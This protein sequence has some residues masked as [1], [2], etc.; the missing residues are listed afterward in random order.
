MSRRTCN[1]QRD[2][3]STESHRKE[4]DYRTLHRLKDNLQALLE[5]ITQAC[6]SNTSDDQLANS[7]LPK[8]TSHETFLGL[9][10]KAEKRIAARHRRNSHPDLSKLSEDH[11]SIDEHFDITDKFQEYF[12]ELVSLQ[13]RMNDSIAKGIEEAL[14]Q[15]KD[16]H[17][18]MEA[19]Q[20]EKHMMGS[21]FNNQF[22]QLQKVEA[23]R[24]EEVERRLEAVKYRKEADTRFEKQRVQLSIATQ[25]VNRLKQVSEAATY[26]EGK[27]KIELKDQKAETREL[28]Y[29]VEA[30]ENRINIMRDTMKELAKYAHFG[31][32][33]HP[34]GDP[35]TWAPGMVNDF[36]DEWESMLE[37]NERRREVLKLLSKLV[38]LDIK[39]VLGSSVDEVRLFLDET[40]LRW[41][42]LEDAY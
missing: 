16:V 6:L 8:S 2:A 9:Y 27:L 26:R 10:V 24:N 20:R 13:K 12:M 17:C 31:H 3:T 36:F 4:L 23:E 34:V 18:N 41:R 42:E 14:S 1:P 37:R 35:L 11:I 32:E 39:K 5:Y 30:K 15:V 40:G 21:K 29:Q 25:D 19:D 7:T 38:G 22:E 28:Q 33:E